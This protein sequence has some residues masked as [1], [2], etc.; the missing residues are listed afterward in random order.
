MTPWT[1]LQHELHRLRRRPLH[2]HPRQPPLERERSW[3]LSP[4]PE[5][6][7]SQLLPLQGGLTRGRA[8][9]DG[10]DVMECAAAAEPWMNAGW[11]VLM[12]AVWMSIRLCVYSVVGLRR[13]RRS[14][15]TTSTSCACSLGNRCSFCLYH[16]YRAPI[17][18]DTSVLTALVQ[19]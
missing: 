14:S 15:E 13:S 18:L 4:P 10:G 5:P 8:C 11:L 7:L 9:L 2:P 19:L 16:K 6:H 12:Y 17:L 3:H 1:R